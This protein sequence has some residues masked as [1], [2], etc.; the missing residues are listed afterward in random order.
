MHPI[1][2]SRRRLLAYLLAWIPI[3]ALLVWVA[4]A[5]GGAPW[6]DA[7][8]VLAP[9][10]L[11]YAFACLSPW[12]ICQ[13][14]PLRPSGLSYLLPTWGAAAVVVGS[15]L[16]G[17]ARL[18]AYLL[19][20]PAPPAVRSP[21]TTNRPPR[22][23]RPRSAQDRTN[24][25]GAAAWSGKY[26]RAR[27]RQMRSPGRRALGRPPRPARI[28]R[29]KPRPPRPVTPGWESTPVGM[30]AAAGATPESGAWRISSSLR[31]CQRPPR[32]SRRAASGRESADSAERSCP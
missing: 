1:L 18:A 6:R 9:A 27:G 2:A 16:L 13:T 30:P 3:L 7:A 20:R 21:A 14:L 17:G 15:L 5:S 25:R 4:W 12:Y 8:A 26:T 11:V 19:E 23:R 29:R 24:Q 31:R 32:L 10:C 28:R 22:R